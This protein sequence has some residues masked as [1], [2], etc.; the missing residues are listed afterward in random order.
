[1]LLMIFCDLCYSLRCHAALQICLYLA[2]DNV[3]ESLS[4]PHDDSDDGGDSD[5]E[6]VGGGWWKGFFAGFLYILL[7]NFAK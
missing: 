3:I 2:L 4:M 7:E 6:L 1:M 5:V